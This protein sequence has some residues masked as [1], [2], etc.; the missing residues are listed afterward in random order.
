MLDGEVD[1]GG[2]RTCGRQARQGSKMDLSD[3][4]VASFRGQ[5]CPRH[6]S[7]FTVTVSNSAPLTT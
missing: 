1:I 4:L 2:I 5:E 6:T 7:Y 3:V